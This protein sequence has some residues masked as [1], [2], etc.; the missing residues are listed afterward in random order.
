MK[1]GEFLTSYCSRTLG[2]ANNVRFGG[3]KMDDTTIVEKV[4]CSLTPKFDHG[5]YSNEESSDI[6]DLFLDELQ[7]SLLAHEQKMNK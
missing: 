6:D 5:V 2:I 1:E 3:Q 4:I 7:S